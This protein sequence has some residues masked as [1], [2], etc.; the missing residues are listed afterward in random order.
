MFATQMFVQRQEFCFEFLNTL[1]YQSMLQGRGWGKCISSPLVWGGKRKIKEVSPFE[2]L[3]PCFI[4]TSCCL[5]EPWRMDWSVC[6][7]AGM[8]GGREEERSKNIPPLPLAS[9]RDGGTGATWICDATSLAWMQ[10]PE[11]QE[12]GPFPIIFK[13]ALFFGGLP[14]GFI[15]QQP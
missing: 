6:E 14:L 11:P 1:E 9:C 13:P 4:S 7:G 3:M 8:R 15:A 12:T 5:N 10:M 2:I